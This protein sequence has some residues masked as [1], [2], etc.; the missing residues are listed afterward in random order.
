M[1]QAGGVKEQR[2][3]KFYIVAT[4]SFLDPHRLIIK[5]GET[6]GV[7]ERFGDIIPMGKREQGLYHEGTRFLSRY[8]LTI[9]GNRPLFLSSNVDEDNIFITVDLTNPDMRMKGTL[10]MKRDTVHIMRSRLISTASCLEHIRLRHFGENP[11]DFAVDL[12]FDA[13]FYDIFEVRGMKRKARGKLLPPQMKRNR[14]SFVYKGLDGITRETQMNFSRPPSNIGDKNR[15]VS[16]KVRLQP[17]KTEDIHFTISCVLSKGPLPP[18]MKFEEARKKARQK[19]TRVKK[20]SVDIDT[21]NEQFNQSV[22]Q[23]LSDIRMMLT[24]TEYGLYPYGGIPW[25][26]TPFGR[27]ALVTALETLWLDPAL[28]KGVLRYLAAKQARDFDKDKEAEP[29]KI[30]HEKRSGEMANLNE[31]PFSLYY[32]SVDSTPLF[33]MLAAAYYK[34]TG[35]AEL[36]KGLWDNIEM[37]L[38]WMD[39]YGDP[40]GDGFLEYTGS[41]KGLINQGWKDSADSVFHKDGSFPRPPVA[42]CEVQGYAYAAKLGGAELAALAGKTNFAEKL[43]REAEELRKNFDAQFWDEQMG[44]FV[45]A[46]DGDKKPCRVM[47]SNAGQVLYSG[48]AYPKRAAVMAEKLINEP[49]FSGWGIRTLSAKEVRYN[50]ISYHNGSVWPHDNALIAAGLARYR[51]REQFVKVFGG[52]F[53]ASLYMEFQRLPELFC[54]FH[55]RKGQS[56]TL[57][58]VACTPQTWASGALILML[59]ASLGIEFEP[60]NNKII[61]NHPT[62]P[63]FV[64]RVQLKNLSVTPK[65]SID[66][67]IR[68][69]GE[70]VTTEVM[71]KPADVIITVF[72]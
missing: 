48:I 22:K 38:L 37:A 5:D 41:R 69:F 47:A 3:D 8:E 67:Q 21:S 59:Q 64:N 16:F 46:L 12:A 39:N 66:I 1:P 27:D 10:E 52:M 11:V 36:I 28:P 63:E 7:F 6:F 32:G 14:L 43:R 68:R 56:P 58:P 55:R 42:L 40:D 60:E 29:G 72:K 62:L 30:L 49:M 57:Y 53:E 71:R 33:V 31:I 54:G 23:S 34:R 4:A 19:I 9:N 2:G 24:Q 65:K 20:E 44:A 15:R 25:Y 70:S 50:P 35:D 18:P 61:F 13:D 17:G 45:L 26:C 51:L